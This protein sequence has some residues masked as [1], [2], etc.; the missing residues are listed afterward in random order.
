[1]LPWVN[2]AGGPSRMWPAPLLWFYFP[3]PAR[4]LLVKKG[5]TES[6]SK[7]CLKHGPLLG[8]YQ[9]RG[10]QPDCGSRAVLRLPPEEAAAHVKYQM[11]QMIADSR[12]AHLIP[13]VH[14]VQLAHAATYSITSSQ[15]HWRLFPLPIISIFSFLSSSLLTAAPHD[16]RRHVSPRNY[17]ALQGVQQQTA[18]GEVGAS[19]PHFSTQMSGSPGHSYHACNFKA[20]QSE[21][22][23][24][25]ITSLAVIWDCNF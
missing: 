12:K 2:L 8:R 4:G 13:V 19:T 15:H 18:V 20:E 21:P 11:T 17:R 23:L 14:T 9:H 7:Y 16:E 25:N 10:A 6:G 22:F 3:R 1:M 24:H 5:R